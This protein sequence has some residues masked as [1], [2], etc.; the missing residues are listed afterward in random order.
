MKILIAEDDLLLSKIIEV[1][2]KKDGHETIIATDGQEALNKLDLH[3]DLLILD[4]MMPFYSGLE[5]IEYMRSK[6]NSSTPIIILSALGQEDTV[7]QAFKL[8]ATDYITKPFSPNE[9]LA[10]VKARTLKLDNSIL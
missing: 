7:L 4:I 2:L 10:R 5:I 6:L 1:R 9:L 3:P 8:G